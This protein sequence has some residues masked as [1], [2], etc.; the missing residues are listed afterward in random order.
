MLT[1]ALIFQN[2]TGGAPGLH[3]LLIVLAG[4]FLFFASFPMWWREGGP[5]VYS[6]NCGWFGLLCWL[7]STLY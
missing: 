6:S 5:W 3:T 4:V 7:L 1:L 2:H